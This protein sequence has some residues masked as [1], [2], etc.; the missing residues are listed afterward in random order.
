LSRMI[1]SLENF[2][3][4]HCL[5]SVG[6]EYNCQ[7]RR[8]RRSRNFFFYR[9]ATTSR[10]DSRVILRPWFLPVHHNY[11]KHFI[12]LRPE[13]V[14]LPAAIVNGTWR[15]AASE[16]LVRQRSARYWTLM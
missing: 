9:W 16:I 14:Q 8:P 13:V 5:G 6:V 1:I 4:P 11:M 12:V 10:E 15:L 2:H 3:W 7:V